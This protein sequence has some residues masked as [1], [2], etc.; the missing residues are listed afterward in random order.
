MLLALGQHRPLI[1]PYTRSIISLRLRDASIS[2]PRLPC[3][4]L[5]AFISQCAFTM[6]VDDTSKKDTKLV[7]LSE[8]PSSSSPGPSTQVAPPPSF[9]ETVGIRSSVIDELNSNTYAPPGGEEPPPAFVP[10]EAEYFED[11]EGTIVSHDPH[12]NED[13]MTAALLLCISRTYSL[14]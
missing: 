7:D 8:L 9:E 10:Y 12:L 14:F 2:C 6:I 11:D 5:H 1:A 13:G 3:L 4:S